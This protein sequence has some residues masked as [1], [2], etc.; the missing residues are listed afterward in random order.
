M[1]SEF[2]ETVNTKRFFELCSEL[3]D[4]SSM[5]GPSLAMVTG[6]AGRGKT[7]AARR[8]ATQTEAI[9]LPPLNTRTPTMVLREIAFEL[10]GMRPVRSDAC[11]A[12]IGDEMAKQRRL[13]MIDE[14]DLLAMQILEMLRNVNERY[15]CPILLI[16]E[17]DLKGRIASRRRLQSRIRVRLEF[18]PVTQQDVAFF[19][20]QSLLDDYPPQA[21]SALITQHAKGDWRP[22][23]TAAIDI[24]RAMKATGTNEITVE[25]TKDVLKSA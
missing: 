17:D 20:K 23:V 16:G 11:L 10:A 19:F 7:E 22:V 9:Y 5:I 13:I 21:V 15:A 14:A 8:F 4:P 2:I 25:I 18:G 1:K 12:I 24:E 6:P 3:S